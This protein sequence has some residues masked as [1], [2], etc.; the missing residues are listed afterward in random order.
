MNWNIETAID[1]YRIKAWGDGYFTLNQRGDLCV[2]VDPDNPSQTISLPELLHTLRQRHIHT[3]LLVRFTD[4]LKH[5]ITS[6]ERS[7]QGARERFHY[8]G[9]YYPVYP[10]KVNQQAQVISSL[11]QAGSANFGLEA[12]SKPELLAVMASLPIE[13]GLIVWSI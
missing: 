10:I 7:F 13:Q 12:G 6:L 2:V 8:S 4:I 3:P 11:V 9:E 1:T 5:R